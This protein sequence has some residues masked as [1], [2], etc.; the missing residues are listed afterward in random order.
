M[1][2]PNPFRGQYGLL[3]AGK[4]SPAQP[5]RRQHQTWRRRTRSSCGNGQSVPSSRSV[6]RFLRRSQPRS[7]GKTPIYLRN[8]SYCGLR[9]YQASSIRLTLSSNCMRSRPSAPAQIW[10]T[11]DSR[12]R[13]LHH[14][15][16]MALI[17]PRCHWTGRARHF[18]TA[19]ATSSPSSV[20]PIP[21]RRAARQTRG[22][23]RQVRGHQG[24][25]G[26]GSFPTRPA[27]RQPPG[28]AGG[29]VPGLAGSG[30]AAPSGL[31]RH[32]L[33]GP[34]RPRGLAPAPLTDPIPVLCWA[35]RA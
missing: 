5:G 15:C 1:R 14:R 20:P 28:A 6:F 34:P 17:I 22:R 23:A 2:A 32:H 30:A 7:S 10:P 29:S 16:S 13:L 19:P 24:L 12:S 35:R 21:R 11:L 8:S 9:T 27:G 3:L 4:S 33:A 26:I 31:L 25:I 18:T